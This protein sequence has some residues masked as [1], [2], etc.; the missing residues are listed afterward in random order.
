MSEQ[1][2][3]NV[4]QKA[5]N[6]YQNQIKNLQSFEVPEWETTIY[7]RP[8]TT[9]AQEAEV[10]ELAKVGK[11]VEAMVVT[12]INK[13]RHEDGS[14][15]FNKHD[16]NALLNEVDPNVILRISEKINGGALPKVEE[17]EKN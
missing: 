5:T 17:M 1:K 2:K 13:A 10:I 4:L 11:T 14:R 6:H 16:R 9:L 3:P 8:V 12:I 7:Y 15:M